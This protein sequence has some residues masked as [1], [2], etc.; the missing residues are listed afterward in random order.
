MGRY[1]VFVLFIAMATLAGCAKP[2]QNNHNA[3]ATN[4]SSAN[5]SAGAAQP[6]N[7]LLREVNAGNVDGVRQLIDN[8]ANVNGT[9]EVGV[10]PLM[11]ASGIGNKEIVELL[12]AKGANVN[13]R[14]SG[15]Y[16]ALMQAALVG[17]TEIVKLLLDAGADPTVKDIAGKSAQTYAEEKGHKEIAAMLKNKK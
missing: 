14:S 1:R 15:N 16:T 2:A 9:N 13:A 17:Q 11:N 8:G 6:D 12:I 5:S 3:R 7:T 10:T 4:Q